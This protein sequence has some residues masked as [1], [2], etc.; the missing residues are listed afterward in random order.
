MSTGS[1]LTGGAGNNWLGICCLKGQFTSSSGCISS[2]PDL[3]IWVH[4]F[5]RELSLSSVKINVTVTGDDESDTDDFNSF[6]PSEARE[7]TLVTRSWFY[8][9]PHFQ[10][11]TCFFFFFSLYEHIYK[12][13][14]VYIFLYVSLSLS[15]LTAV[16]AV[17]FYCASLI[18]T[19][20]VIIDNHGWYFLLFLHRRSI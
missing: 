20:Q 12:Y 11:Q 17:P 18:E 7:F 19:V 4:L 6:R 14:C 3:N 16:V 10:I 13:M 9:L 1:F 5:T 15:R 8:M 2:S